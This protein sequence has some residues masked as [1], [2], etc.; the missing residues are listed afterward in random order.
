MDTQQPVE[1]VVVHHGPTVLRVCRIVLALHHA[2]DAWSETFLSAP[3]V[4]PDLP[5]TAKTETCW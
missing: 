2:Q 5:E 3:S 1:K 4:C